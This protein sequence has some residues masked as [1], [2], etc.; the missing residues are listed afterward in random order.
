MVY[1]AKKKNHAGED[2]MNE[3]TSKKRSRSSSSP[4]KYRSL[5]VLLTLLLTFFTS[6]A[7]AVDDDVPFFA[8]A[9][10]APNIM[11]IFDNSDS[12]QDIPYLRADGRVVRPG[13]NP[14]SAD[15]TG[16]KDWPW[17]YGVKL[18]ADNTVLES[19]GNV[20]YDKNAFPS[21]TEPA[22]PEQDPL[23]LPGNGTLSSTADTNDTLTP[24]VIPSQILT[25]L[26]GKLT[27]SSGVTSTLRNY[28]IY[29]TSLDWTD[30]S[31]TND[32]TYNQ[33]YMW[34]LVEVT[35]FGGNSTYRTISSRSVS[36]KYFNIDTSA[37]AGGALDY[38]N[39]PYTYRILSDIPGSVTRGYNN[40]YVIDAG[41][42]WQDSSIDNS[43]NKKIITITSGTNAGESRIINGRHSYYKYWRVSVSFPANCDHTT[44]YVITSEASNTERVYDASLD[45]TT[46]ATV[47]TDDTLFNTNYRYRLIEVTSATGTVQQRTIK[48]RDTTGGYFTVDIRPV[49]GGPLVYEQ[50][51]RPYTYTILTNGPGAVTRVDTNLRKVVDADLNW[52]QIVTDFDSQ[53]KNRAIIITAGTN[54]GEKR[55]ITSKNSNYKYWYVDTAFPVAC[56]LTTKYKIIGSA[57]DNRYAIGGNHPASKLYQAKKAVQLFLQDPS[58]KVCTSTDAAGTCLTERYAINMGFATYLSAKIPRVTARY[59]RLRPGSTY[60]PPPVPDR[61][62]GY[63]KRERDK[64]DVFY[65]PS[66]N[67]NFTASGW[68]SRPVGTT[69]WQ[70]NRSYSGVSVGWQFEM[71]YRSGHCD[72]QTIRYTLVSILPKGS[73]SLPYQYEFTFK[74]RVSVGSEGGYW[75]RQR[76]CFNSPGVSDCSA[77]PITY[78]SETLIPPVGGAC[79]LP[80]YEI[81][82][83]DDDPYTTA[84][85][86]QSTYAET[87]GHYNITNTTSAGY[88]DP[89]TH[90]VTPRTISGWTLVTTAM[91]GVVINNS[92]DTGDILPNTHDTSYFMYPGEGTSDRPHGWSYKKTSQPWIYGASDNWGNRVNFPILKWNWAY[93]PNYPSPG[94]AG[95]WDASV[96]GDS[97]QSDPYFPAVVGDEMSNFTGDDQSVFVNLP[98][99][100]PTDALYGDDVSGT[101]IAK[102][103]EYTNISRISSPRIENWWT[104][105]HD[106]TM[107]PYSKSLAPNVYSTIQGSGTPIAASLADVKKYYSEYIN[108]DSMTLG[109]CRTN[110]VIFLTDGLETGVVGTAAERQAAAVAAATALNNFTIDGELYSVKTYVVGFGLDVA[111]QA[112]LNAIALAGGTGTAYFANNVEQLVNILV[113]EITS[114]IVGDTY[115]RAAPV[116][117]KYDAGNPLRLYTANFDYPSWKGHLNAYEVDPN[118]GLIDGPAPGWNSDCD[119]VAG[120][121]ADAGCE[122]EQFGRGTVYSSYRSATTLERVLFDPTNLTTVGYLKSLINPLGLDIDGDTILDTNADVQTI[123]NYTLD[124]GYDGGSYK[125]SRDV[126]WFLGD[127]YN[128]A[129]VV[130]GPPTFIPPDPP[131]VGVD[132][133]EGYTAYKADVS[134]RAT[135]IYVGANDGMVHA[136]NP[137]DGREDWAYI[138]NSVLGKINEFREGHRFTVDLP[139]RASDIYSPGGVG[140]IWSAVGPGNEKE[141]WHTILS[142]G[143]R[144]GG[145]SYFGLDVTDPTNPQPAW[146]MSD[147][148]ADPSTRDMGKTWSSPGIGRVMIDGVNTSVLFV[149]GGLSNDSNKGNNFYIINAGSGVILKEFAIGSS[150]NSVAAEPLLVAD[151]QKASSNYGNIVKGYFGD[152]A[153]DL[154]KLDNLNDALGGTAWSPSATLLH[155]GDGKVF[156][157]PTISESN[158]GCLV[159]VGGNEYTINSG[160]TFVLYG[161]GDEEFPTDLTTTDHIY[162]VADPPLTPVLATN[163]P[164]TRIWEQTLPV[165]EKL[166]TDPF[167]HLNTAYFITYTPEGGC[168]QGESF[169]WGLTMPRCGDA[170]GEP[171]ILYDLSG[172]K[173]GGPWKRIS[174]GAGITSSPTHG[175]PVMYVQKP[176]G[177]QPAVIQLPDSNKLEYWRENL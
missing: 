173:T 136:F 50:A 121:D 163:L 98:A 117:T 174:L 107:M 76:R 158:G 166:L 66:S 116:I 154:Y 144:A 147:V 105:Y 46:P 167:I 142:S 4:H 124:A 126:D 9:N 34:R 115:S 37:A 99:Y 138:P 84:D 137:D 70:S 119:T 165:A 74:S 161:T 55:Q 10:G 145:Y 1:D 109:G 129:P 170:G 23:K 41:I 93:K 75:Y 77:L 120:A 87:W 27:L 5:F 133:Y 71:K 48:S 101:G 159:T 118:S 15:N 102:I 39:P 8:G 7:C 56:D 95:G 31:L 97:I 2:G 134:G 47:L 122:M 11:F 14:N 16:R 157:K 127:I 175:G 22:I 135:R 132:P 177:G 58:L 91:T 113:T 85:Y 103:L 146:E 125:G 19:S 29:D 104:Q 35:D 13:T 67:V 150:T 106:F 72:E 30:A 94:V 40:T 149:G 59:V 38:S 160:T 44:R 90:L 131:T 143:L 128:S 151:L 78:G 164:L 62:C 88:V 53:W 33:T 43:W 86:Y 153:G 20:Q 26:P 65:S 112:T 64:S 45:W 80:C 21:D 152:T 73:D 92:G 69:S 63:Y 155:D 156:H 176:G 123:M 18:N 140:T 32:T 148:D 171:G 130:I 49:A 139:L 96:W 172:S 3:I 83:H 68:D 25:S 36:G 108:L 81:P 51:E 162:A 89:T 28:R 42:D 54:S 24:N 61:Y 82:A 12:M 168:A 169:L 79:Y 17:R 52:P 100:D 111:S 110:Y 57:D 141:G 114:S 60:D 6:P